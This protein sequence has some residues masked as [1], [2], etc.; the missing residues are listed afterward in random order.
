[1]KASVFFEER[2][3]LIEQVSNM[4]DDLDMASDRVG[5]AYLDNDFS[6]ELRCV[7]C[8]DVY[9]PFDGDGRKVFVKVV[10]EDCEEQWSICCC[11]DEKDFEEYRT[12]DDAEELKS[13]LE[14]VFCEFFNDLDEYIDEPEDWECEEDEDEE[15]E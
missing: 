6:G 15:D 4:V 3:C 11:E 2:D 14:D 8:G 12:Y 9:V 1:M 10:N 7:L 5:S 13:D